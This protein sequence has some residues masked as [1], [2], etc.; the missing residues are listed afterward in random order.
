MD[1]CL[2]RLKKAGVYAAFGGCYLS[3]VLIWAYQACVYDT[4]TLPADYNTVCDK[5]IEEN[6]IIILFK[7]LWYY[8]LIIINN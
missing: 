8:F 5:P 6:I 1:F 2:G 3:V 4:E 7:A